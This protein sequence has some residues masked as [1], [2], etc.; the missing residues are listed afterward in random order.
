MAVTKRIALGAM[1]AALV[2]G[3]AG[4]VGSGSGAA[5]AA[6]KAAGKDSPA[7]APKG[8]V[9]LIGDGSTAF[10]GVQP[11][12]P[13]PRRLAAG[14]KPPQFVVFSWDGAGEDSQKLFS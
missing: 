3:L 2:A 12:L 6:K 4:C 5:N 14:Q 11:H 7:G 1:A 10:T 13:T 9:T 8:A